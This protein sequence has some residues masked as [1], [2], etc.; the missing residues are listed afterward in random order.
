MEHPEAAADGGVV[1]SYRGGVE[2][3]AEA[4]L[5]IWCEWACL[6][7]HWSLKSGKV[8][9]SWHCG[10]QSQEPM[11]ELKRLLGHMKVQYIPCYCW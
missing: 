11:G 10:Y 7:T 3:A 2:A 4:R 5:I 6:F 9:A 8:A 1:K